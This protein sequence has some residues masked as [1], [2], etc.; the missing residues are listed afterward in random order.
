MLNRSYFFKYTLTIAILFLCGCLKTSTDEYQLGTTA[1]QKADYD[2]AIEHYELAMTSYLE[3]FGE[4]HAKVARTYNA[5]GLAWKSKGNHD[6]AIKYFAFALASSLKAFGETHHEVAIVR[7][8]L[9]L[10]LH[11]KGR[12]NTAIN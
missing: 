7:G 1:Y 12:Y 6:K 8:N 4:A 11:Q 9:G 5:L 10:V 2:K 3:S